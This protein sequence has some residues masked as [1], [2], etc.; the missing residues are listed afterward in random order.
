MIKVCRA[1]VM[2]LM[3]STWLIQINSFV[4]RPGHGPQLQPCRCQ[5]RRDGFWKRTSGYLGLETG[6]CTGSL[7]AKLHRHSGHH[8]GNSLG[9]RYLVSSESGIYGGR[10]GIPAQRLRSEGSLHA[11]RL[12]ADCLG[13]C[14][15]GGH[16]KGHDY[17]HGRQADTG[18]QLQ[19]LHKHPQYLRCHKV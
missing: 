4:H 14:Q 9:R 11:A 6:R 1:S 19:A 3:E 13:G 2:L 18:R 15:N 5:D 16:R 8:V 10:T 17:S 7:F 12:L